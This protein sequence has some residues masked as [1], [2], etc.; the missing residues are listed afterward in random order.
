MLL[1]PVHGDGGDG[2]A[3]GVEDVLQ[4]HPGKYMSGYFWA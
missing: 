1:L 3:M 4:L 2:V